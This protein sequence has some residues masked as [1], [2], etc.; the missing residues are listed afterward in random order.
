MNDKRSFEK[1]PLDGNYIEA[2]WQDYK[3]TVISEEAGEIQLRE[4]KAAFIAGAAIATGA[5]TRAPAELED[6]K[7][8]EIFLTELVNSIQGMAE[9][10]GHSYPKE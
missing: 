4:T 3:D 8:F 7:A 10:V 1:A 5:F 6:E 9:E 2:C